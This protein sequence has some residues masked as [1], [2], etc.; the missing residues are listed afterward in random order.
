MA[1]EHVSGLI[2]IIKKRLKRVENNFLATYFSSDKE[3][4]EVL[5]CLPDKQ[6]ALNSK[7][8]AFFLPTASKD[9]IEAALGRVFN[10]KAFRKKKPTYDGFDLCRKYG[11]V[12]CPYCNIDNIKTI[13]LSKSKEKLLSPPLD[14][15]HCQQEYPLL[16]IS[17]YNLVP[18]CWPCNTVFKGK[19]AIDTITHLNPHLDG[20]EQ[21][22]VFAIVGVRNIDDILGKKARNF[23]VKLHNLT[24]D[25]RFDG[26]NSLFELEKR[27]NG[28]QQAAFDAL[29]LVRK[30]SKS[31]LKAIKSLMKTSSIPYRAYTKK[32]YDSNSLHEVPFAK[33][34]R[35][36][37]DQYGSAGLKKILGF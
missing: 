29:D 13:Y 19:K 31:D 18:S 2:D 33:I 37:F 25:K 21:D 15:Y 23:K 28:H 24:R 16:A 10:Y 6:L 34:T 35:D 8:M 22:C 5:K 32:P 20:F 36:I 26:N 11:F 17:F 14:H 1:N 30:R 7:V 3:I 4:R 9:D 12:T 27:Y